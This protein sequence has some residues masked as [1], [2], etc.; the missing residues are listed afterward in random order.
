MI[1]KCISGVLVVAATAM[2]AGQTPARY[3]GAAEQIFTGTV[4]AVAAY[5]AVDGS[6]GVHIDLQTDDGVLD[7]RIG[8]AMYI[9]QNNFYF[10]AGDS[11]VVIGARTPDAD[12]PILAKAVQKGSDLLVL[13][14]AEG[15]TK[16][17]P[18][19]EGVDG[20]GVNHLPLQRTTLQ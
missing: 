5:P 3:N 14:S 7:L 15:A 13:R 19:T 6:V 11:L 17:M 8:P 12:G 18:A 4:K 9:G 16:W 10:F 20:C 1:S 2:L